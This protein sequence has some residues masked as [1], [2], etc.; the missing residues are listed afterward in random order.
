MRSHF[1]SV[2]IQKINKVNEILSLTLNKNQIYYSFQFYNV[3]MCLNVNEYFF[4]SLSESV[5]LVQKDL[6]NELPYV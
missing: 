1:P 5:F 2:D 6:S 4:H 3:H